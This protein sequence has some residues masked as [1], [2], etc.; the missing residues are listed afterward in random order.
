MNPPAQLPIAPRLLN[1]FD[2]Y[3]RHDLPW[4][5]PR[6][7]YRVWLSEIMLQQTQV[8]TVIGYFTR[9]VTALPDLPS[10]AAAPTDTVLA[11][12]AGLGYYSRA[13]NLQRAAQLCMERHGGE[14]P[15]DAEALAALPGIG[16]STAGAILAQAWGLP[17]AIL[18]GNVKR[19]LARFHAVHGY[20]GTTETAR[21]LWGH[22][23]SHLPA[24]RLADYTQALMDLGA[25]VCQ[26]ARPLCTTCPLAADC[27]AYRQG[28]VGQLPSRKP[29]K[30]VPTRQTCVLILRD[31]TGR[32]LLHRRPATGVW[33]ELWSLPETPS[34][35]QAASAARSLG[36]RTDGFE[37]LPS[38]THVFSHYKLEI[39]PLL[40]RAT[41]ANQAGEMPDLRWCDSQALTEVGLPAP[42]KRLLGDLTGTTQSL[43]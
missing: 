27:A 22:A 34:A 35:S 13:R 5:S 7:P 33:A 2:Q 10:L 37:V 30:A 17:H 36:V 3:G 24:R 12:W 38:F 6:T 15:R 31:E 25:T 40:A 16:R 43:F 14:L 21:V 4:Q 9:F 29:A 19:V 8:A 23:E 41:P 18:D 39:Q 42:I 1:W 32:T 28:I 11:L 26:R 20:P